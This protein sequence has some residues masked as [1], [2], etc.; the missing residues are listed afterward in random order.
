MTIYLLK[1]YEVLGKTLGFKLMAIH[2]IP[3][4]MQILMEGTLTKK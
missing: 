3:S 2:I 4:L 1:I